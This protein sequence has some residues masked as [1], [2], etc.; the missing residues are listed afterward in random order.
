MIARQIPNLITGLRLL[1][2]PPLLLLLI[3]RQFLAALILFA[4]MGV[5]DALDGFLAK[6][7]GWHSRLG[8][9]LDPM[10]DKVMQISSF[11]ALG[12]LQLLPVWL[13]ALVILRDVVIVCG[14]VAYRLLVGA[15]EISPSLISKVNTFMQIVLV[16]AV[17]LFQLVPQPDWALPLLIALTA[18]TTIVSGLD[19]VLE[20]S[21]RY[22]AQ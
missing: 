11:I 4:M 8:S 14:A 18:L 13:V 12:W 5:S 7:Y 21:R 6:Y 15:L 2:V 10:A 19:Y 1:L 20:W 3:N 16:L 17:I 9:Y 22:G